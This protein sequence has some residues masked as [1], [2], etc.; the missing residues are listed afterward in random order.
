MDDRL[1]LLTK[2]NL[3]SVAQVSPNKCDILV[4]CAGFEER[5]V[6]FLRDVV[7]RQSSCKVI[8]IEYA[9][10]I[11]QNR[12]QEITNLCEDARLEVSC[13]LYDRKNPAGFG[14]TLMRSL[15][16]CSGSIYLDISAMSRLLIVQALVV[17]RGRSLGFDRCHVIFAEAASY[18]PT[19]AEVDEEMRKS[20][21]DPQFAALFLSRGVSEVILL[22]ELSPV[23]MGANQSRLIVFPSFNAD[24][25]SVLQSEL[26]PSRISYIHGIPPNPENQWRR[27]AIA[28]IN[29]IDSSS[30]EHLNASTLDYSETLDVLIGLYRNHSI[31]ERLLIA[32]TGSK[33]QSVAVGIFCAFIEDV[34]IV[35]PTPREFRFPERYTNG[36]GPMYELDL[37]AFS[38]VINY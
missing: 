14:E 23:S 4:V 25:L 2:P 28:R 36:I 7:S 33:M 32:P 16:D 19:E 27:D 13:I 3:E 10:L 31:R 5:A 37:S 15:V 17:L 34:Q 9:P 11:P 6:A 29:H 26:Q 1:A 24:Q 8:I 12:L 38:G 20:D 35:Y 21:L 18:P 22:P 30:S